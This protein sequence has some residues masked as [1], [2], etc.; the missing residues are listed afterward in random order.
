MAKSKKFL[1]SDQLE[2]KFDKPNFV[3]LNQEIKYI[4]SKAIAGC[5]KSRWQIAE[6]LSEMV[7]REITVTMLNHWTAESKAGHRMPAEIIPAFCITTNNY[8]LIRLLSQAC[9][10]KFLESQEAI[11]AEV[12]QLD[13]QIKKKESKKQELMRFYYARNSGKKE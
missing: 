1:A 7:G 12:A 3:K 8:D 9:R 10:G 2:L 5:E 4:T 11:L 6:E 13:K